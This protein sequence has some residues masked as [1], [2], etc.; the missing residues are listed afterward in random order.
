MLRRFCLYGFLKNQRYFEP[1]L[2]LALLDKGLSYFTIGLLIAFR[3]VCINLLEV[4]SGSVADVYGRRRAL[5]VSFAAYAASFLVF[6]TADGLPLLALAMFLFAIGEAF[7]S[8]THKALIFAWLR[9]QDRLSER[10][11]VYGYTRSWSQIGSAVSVVIAAV[12]VFAIGDYEWV[13]LLST[14]PCVLNVVNFLG[15][16]QELDAP[17]RGS[18]ALSVVLRHTR[19]ALR[20]AAREPRLRRLMLESMCFEG[21]FD[22]VKGYLQPALNALATSAA[23]A[24]GIAISGQQSTAALVGVVYLGLHLLAAAASRNAY[25]VEERAGGLERGA[26]MMWR[27]MAATYAVAAMAGYIAAVAVLVAALVAL[28]VLQ[29]LWR[30]VIISRFDA[31][32]DESVGAT[33]LSIESQSQRVATMIVAPLIGLAVDT[34]R[35]AGAGEFWPVGAVGLLLALPFVIWRAPQ[36]LATQTPARQISVHDP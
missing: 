32:S 23:V 21:V 18:V 30:P 24:V 12:L 6:A 29:S 7:R 25:R 3:E 17:S 31:H 10:T 22:A 19:D 28:H 27:I 16:P 13:F 34:L 5:I 36:P 8:G 1:F 9:Q 33:V 2:I 35:A 11:R 4:P 15:Y 20:T 14:V 26:G